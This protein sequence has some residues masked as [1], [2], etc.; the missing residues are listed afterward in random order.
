MEVDHVATRNSVF[1]AEAVDFRASVLGFDDLIF[2]DEYL[3][4]RGAYLQRLDYD[5]NGDFL[6]MAFENF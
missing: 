4:I 2:G 5:I 3:F 1:G 6:E